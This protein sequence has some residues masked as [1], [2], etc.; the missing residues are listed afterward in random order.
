MNPV[1]KILGKDASKNRFRRTR[2]S[3]EVECP[4]CGSTN[5]RHYGVHRDKYAGK[6]Y[7]MWEC[8][9]CGKSFEAEW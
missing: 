3:G 2:P 5:I 7:Q 6:I 1:K 8:K 9:D 4:Y